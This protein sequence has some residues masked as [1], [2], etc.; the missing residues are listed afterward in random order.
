MRLQIIF[1]RI[2]FQLNRTARYTPEWDYWS[3]VLK[4]LGRGT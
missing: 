2:Y 4:E 3:A 1:D